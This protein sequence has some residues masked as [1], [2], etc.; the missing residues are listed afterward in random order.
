MI[1]CR[2]SLLM[3]DDSDRKFIVSDKV[4][5]GFHPSCLQVL[6]L[7]KKCFLLDKRGGSGG[8]V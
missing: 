3:M 5:G 2:N 8:E 1:F 6:F 4:V 7:V